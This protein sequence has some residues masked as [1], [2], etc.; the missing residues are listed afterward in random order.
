MYSVYLASRFLASKYS[1]FSKLEIK[2]NVES[3]IKKAELLQQEV[4]NI[5]VFVPHLF[6]YWEK[7]YK[8]DYDVWMLMNTHWLRRCDVLYAHTISPGV[9]NEIQLAQSLGIPVVFDKEELED[10]I[11]LFIEKGYKPRGV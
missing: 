7:Q 2:R 6:H 5:I 9:I 1:N 4:G 8:H 10:V 11:H 3:A